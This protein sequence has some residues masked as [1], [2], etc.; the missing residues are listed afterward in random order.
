[1]DIKFKFD[2][3][4]GL[5]TKLDKAAARGRFALAAVDA[6]NLVTKRADESLRRGETAGINLTPAYVKS[7]TDVVLAS[8]GTKARA[9]ITTKGD[10]TVMSNFG[11]SMASMERGTGA[12]LRAGPR[13]GRRN[14]GT[15]YTI[16]K[17]SPGFEAQWFVMPLRKGKEAG[18]NGFGVFVRDDRIKPGA[19]E[20]R[21][22]KAGKRHIYGPSP[23][24]LFKHQIGIQGGDISDD[25][26][27]TALQQMGDILE[28]AFA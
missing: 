14:A 13:A 18:L 3:L 19:N 1:M 27:R 17:G 15:K 5:A 4:E 26:R 23:Y 22:G 8:T 25:L 7:K 10:L 21:P 16:K 20:L 28:D 24:S 2:A 12:V 6:V 11:V 9:T